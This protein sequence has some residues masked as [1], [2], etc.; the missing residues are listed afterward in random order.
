MLHENPQGQACEHESLS[1][2]TFCGLTR[3]RAAARKFAEPP[4]EGD[5]ARSAVQARAYDALYGAHLEGRA[6]F[7][8]ENVRR[9]RA[10][11]TDFEA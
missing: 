4:T 6:P 3:D 1:G 2:A 7:S 9:A 10:G 8:P 5:L 11:R